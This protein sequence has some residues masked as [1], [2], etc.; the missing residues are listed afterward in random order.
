LI[1]VI[2]LRFKKQ[3]HKTLRER[4][5][6]GVSEVF[7]QVKG[8]KRIEDAESAL[9]N[10]DC[11]IMSMCGGDDSLFLYNISV[12]MNTSKQLFDFM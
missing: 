9:K 1:Q 5:G 6:K 7:K 2:C 4:Y 12:P 11:Y 3:K 10:R 8:D